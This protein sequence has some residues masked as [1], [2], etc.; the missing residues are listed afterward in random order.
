MPK[1]MR[2]G[3]GV[4]VALRRGPAASAKNAAAAGRRPHICFVAPHAWPV[5]GRD[6]R[7]PVIGGAEVQQTILAR[8]FAAHGFRVSMVCLDYGQAN[9]A[10]IDGV[11]AEE[12]TS[13]L[14]SP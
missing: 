14:Q 8:L 2:V 4:A 9:G 12:H 5:L 1:A 10:M 6:S 11:R 3:R 7:I 13:E